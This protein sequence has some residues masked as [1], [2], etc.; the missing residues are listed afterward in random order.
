MHVIDAIRPGVH[1]FDRV[2]S[3]QCHVADIQRQ[4]DVGGGEESVDLPCG[5]DVRR[6]V[7]VER[8]GQPVAGSEV[9]SACEPLARQIPL[10]VVQREC[11]IV[12]CRVDQELI[13]TL[14]RQDGERR[15]RGDELTAGG[16]HAR[17]IGLEDLIAQGKVQGDVGADGAQARGVEELRGL[18]RGAEETG[19]P[20]LRTVV[21]ARGEGP[22]H[23][24]G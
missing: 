5:L 18:L 3:R 15:A 21:V 1:A 20:E 7:R 9:D 6:D 23:V 10:P 8:R 22:E 12:T 2:S 17:E 16:G 4:R 11:S 24:S 14:V 19:R 13:G